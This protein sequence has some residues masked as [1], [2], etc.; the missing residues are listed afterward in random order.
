MKQFSLNHNGL[1][2]MVEVDQ[3]ALFWYRT[4]LIIN[5]EVADERGLFWGTTRLRANDP[6][7]VTVDVT[8]GLLG[9]RKAVLNDDAGP[10]AL[11]KGR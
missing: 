10:V 6:Q 7:P 2:V 5:N 8:A 9:A 3:G 1:H 11:T 4:R